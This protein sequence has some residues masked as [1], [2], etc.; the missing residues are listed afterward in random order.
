MTETKEWPTMTQ[1]DHSD[2]TTNTYRDQIRKRLKKQQEFQK[3][4]GVWGGVS[5]FLV[6][7]WLFSSPGGYFWPM[8]PILGMGL[9]AYFQWRE[10]YGPM[11][12]REISEADID[13][14]I[15]RINQHK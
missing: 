15:K 12:K 9:G 4:L 6:I 8:W 7:I 2:S 3:F 14:E 1:P 10:A 5:V 13:A 11:E